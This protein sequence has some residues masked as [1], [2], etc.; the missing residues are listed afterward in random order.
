MKVGRTVIMSTHQMYQ[1]EAL[2]DRI[3]LIDHGRTVL[4]G[5]RISS[6]PSA[7]RTTKSVGPSSAWFATSGS[8]PLTRLALRNEL[9]RSCSRAAGR[10]SE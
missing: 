6:L 1:V 8:S 4:C 10:R 7:E 9:K 3:V 2:C 5:P